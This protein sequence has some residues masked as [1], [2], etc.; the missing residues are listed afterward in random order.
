MKQAIRDLQTQDRE[1][2]RS[3]QMSDLERSAARSAAA[4]Q[5]RQE[6]IQESAAFKMQ[7]TV[8]NFE[9]KNQQQ[10]AQNNLKT[11]LNCWFKFQNEQ[12]AREEY[13]FN[14]AVC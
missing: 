4:S 5:L 14:A 2:E 7:Q 1:R 6:Q 12:L 9:L 8:D 11:E 3:N 10:V 13:S